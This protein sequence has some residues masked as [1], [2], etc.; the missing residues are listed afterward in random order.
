M[1]R[2]WDKIWINALA[3]TCIDG[4]G[5]IENAAIG[6]KNGCIVWV[7][8]TQD[9][10]S[11]ADELADEVYD[12]KGRCI[13]PG[14]I[15]CHTHLV[16]AGNRAREFE[17][18][19]QGMSYEAIAKEGGGIQSTVKATRLASEEDLYQQ[20]AKRALALHASGATTV[21]IK[22][23]YGLD[24]AT[25]EKMLRVARSIGETIPMNVCRTFLG[26]HCIPS[27]YLGKANEYVSYVCNAMLPII[28]EKRLATAVDV[29]CEKIAFDLGQ[30]ERVFQT[31]KKYGLRIKC[32]SEQL[33]D[34]GSAELAAH[35]QALSVDHLEHVSPGGIKAIAKSGTVA[36]LLP[37]AY[38]FLREKKMP[39]VTALRQHNV[40]IAIATD[41][42]PGTSPMMSLPLVMN[43]ACTLFCMTPEEAL[44]GVTVNAAKALGIDQD[45]GVI[46]RGKKADLI[47]W[48]VQHPAELSYYMGVSL[49]HQ[50]VKHGEVYCGT[51][52]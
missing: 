12:V 39:P 19:L 17:L 15:D 6:V 9:L 47:V 49:A 4:Y 51:P 32:H 31:A 7:G 3:V 13:T 10:A 21:E 25:E 27:E 2:Q 14:L 40:P 33:S 11:P 41:C 8:R 20:S 48:D 18:R 45:Y 43:M 1:N 37:G 46:S 22:S 29:F 50:I 24:L 36:V 23:G 38:Y 30:T 16:F 5:L 42:N 35:Y 28:A 34:S 44:L 52:K 26:A